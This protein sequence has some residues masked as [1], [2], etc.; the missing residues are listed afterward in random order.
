MNLKSV[1]VAAEGSFETHHWLLPE[2]AEIIYGGLA[3]LIVFGALYKFA[4]P[5][6]K[7]SLAARTERIQKELDDAK[8]QRENA[9]NEAARIRTALGDIQAE[10]AKLLAEAEAQAATVL[11]D[12][13][14]RITAEAADLE[15]KAEADI[16]AASGRL[17]DEIKSEIARLSSVAV[18]RVVKAALNDA[19][20][21]DLIEGFISNVG[22]AR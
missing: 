9:E 5:M 12:G 16:A 21:Q 7:T 1:L 18:D 6:F 10:R 17:N 19:A 11:A 22:A 15:A 8:S 13:R 4:L 3:S 2:T 14:A 20:Q